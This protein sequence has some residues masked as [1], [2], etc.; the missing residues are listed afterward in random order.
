LIAT[1]VQQGL[2]ATVI[3]LLV[4]TKLVAFAIPYFFYREKKILI[5]DEVV[6]NI[7]YLKH[8]K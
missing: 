5:V 1:A 7:D 4:E 6:D 2:T 8:Q 3:T